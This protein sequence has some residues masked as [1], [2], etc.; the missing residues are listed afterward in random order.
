MKFHSS[1][2]VKD[3]NKVAILIPHAHG[4]S[5]HNNMTVI[6]LASDTSV[7]TNQLVISP[8][9][10]TD[11]GI[12]V[13]PIRRMQYCYQCHRPHAS[14]R[15]LQARKVESQSPN[16]HDK[17][18][19]QWLCNPCIVAPNTFMKCRSVN[20]LTLI[21]FPVHPSR[22]EQDHGFICYTCMLNGNIPHCL[23]CG[24]S[25]FHDDDHSIIL[26][27]YTI[28]DGSQCIKRDSH[29]RIMQMQLCRQC[30]VD[31]T[32]FRNCLHPLCTN[33]MM[34]T[35]EVH[36]HCCPCNDSFNHKFACLQCFQE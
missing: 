27:Q 7:H 23:K 10:P 17:H 12:C 13:V 19:F 33:L 26:N 35:E 1:V 3:N 31:R 20:C 8:T 21:I 36:T 32:V 25:P 24:S 11:V 34:H 15:R 16:H 29:S 14:R 2:P 30:A 4:D 5:G 22:L 18:E 28:H 6:Q 9:I